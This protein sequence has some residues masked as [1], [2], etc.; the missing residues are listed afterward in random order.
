MVKKSTLFDIIDMRKFI[1][2]E[3]SPAGACPAEHSA[4][5]WILLKYASLSIGVFTR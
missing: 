3:K 4:F 2:I 1:I 5:H